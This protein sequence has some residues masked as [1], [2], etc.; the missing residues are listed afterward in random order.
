MKG[1]QV[2]SAHCCTAITLTFFQVVQLHRVVELLAQVTC[3]CVRRLKLCCQLGLGL[4]QLL[5]KVRER[6]RNNP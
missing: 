2:T 4:C 1:E 3:R 6:T 5:Q